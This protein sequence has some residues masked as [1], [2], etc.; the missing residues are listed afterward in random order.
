MILNNMVGLPN[1]GKINISAFSFK[2]SSQL[3]INT[4][5]VD[6]EITQTT[7]PTK[8]KIENT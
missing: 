7:E 2:P 4:S 3:Y 1:K 5:S 8:K 6:K